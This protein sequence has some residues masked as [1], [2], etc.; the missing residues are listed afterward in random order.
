MKPRPNPVSLLKSLFQRLASTLRHEDGPVWQA[1]LPL[2]MAVV[3]VRRQP[4]GRCSS[5]LQ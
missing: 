4:A 1:E 3:R 5:R 2:Q